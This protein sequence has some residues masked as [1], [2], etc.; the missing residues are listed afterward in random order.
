MLPVLAG[1]SYTATI[2][3]LG[4]AQVYPMQFFF[5][6]NSPLFGGLY[7]IMKVNHSITPNDMSTSA[8]GIRMRFSPGGGYGAIKPVTL[9]TFRELGDPSDPVPFSKAE[10]QTLSESSASGGDPTAVVVDEG[11]N[12]PVG[13][14]TKEK[15]EAVVKGKGYAWFDSDK[16]YELN[17]VGVRNTAVG[18]AVTNKFDDYITVSYKEGGEWKF[19]SWAATTQPGKTHV[20]NPSRA[21]GVAIMKPG[22]YKD[23]HIIRKHAGKYEALGQNGSITVYR[24]NNKNLNYDLNNDTLQV[25]SNL[26]IN[27]HHSS[28]TGKSWNVNKW[29][30]GC[31]VFQDIKDFN[32]FMSIARK[33][34][35]LH[36]NKF[37]YTLV[38]SGEIS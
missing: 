36:K 37:T 4:N 1:R 35:A 30:A 26:G 2:D 13:G 31:Q 8:E 21:D 7:Q 19:W 22:Q 12:V 5:L 27:I 23:S 11:D 18:T 3:M 32:T 14:Y 29:S 38:E 33:A 16:D 25:S 15:I 34:R 17:I 28:Y 24:D 20:E 6:E 10:R 9:D